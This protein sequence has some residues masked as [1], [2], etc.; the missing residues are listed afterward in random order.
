M[1]R[2]PRLDAPG[3]WHHVMHRGIA[4]RTVFEDDQ[5]I[6]YFLSRVARAARAGWIAIHAYC[7]LTTHFHLL[8]E[9]REPGLSYAMRRILNDYVRWFNRG[10]RRDGALFRGRFSSRQVDSLEYRRVLVRYIDD[11]PVLARLVPE[12]GIYPHGS[13]RAYA[14]RRG[15]LWLE[16]SWIEHEVRA[17]SNSDEYEPSRY[18]ECFGAPPSSA[19]ART[20]EHRI[21]TRGRGRDPLDDLLG[22]APERVLAW[23]RDKARLADQTRIDWPVCDA[24]EISA[25]VRAHACDHGE[26]PVEL[27]RIRSSGWR[28]VEVALLRDLCASTWTEI[29]RRI[30]TGE[31][32]AIRAHRLHGRALLEVSSYGP[33]VSRLASEAIAQCYGARRAAGGFAPR[34]SQAGDGHPRARREERR[35]GA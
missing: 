31:Q 29:G 19:L 35:S 15:P 26:W 1:P 8:I 21:R 9:S 11:N 33:T 28:L 20:V 3:V 7:V 10:R 34:E 23:M 5:D 6:R 16:R 14:C 24:A 32:G 2:A 30:G 18:A 13:A 12:P 4:R 22:A 17:R 27:T 25:L